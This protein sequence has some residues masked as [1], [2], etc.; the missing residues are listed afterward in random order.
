MASFH[1][2][3]AKRET[4]TGAQSPQVVVRAGKHYVCSACG[5]LIE[6]PADVAEQYILVAPSNPQTDTAKPPITRKQTTPSSAS[7][8]PSST[9]KEQA[10]SESPLQHTPAQPLPASSHRPTHSQETS[11]R[12]STRPTS[13]RTR[14]VSRPI[15]AGK[16]IDGLHVPTGKQLDGAFKWISFQLKVLDRKDSEIKQLKKLLRQQAARPKPRGR[17]QPAGKESDNQAAIK[18][19]RRAAIEHAHADVGKAP[20]Y[21]APAREPPSP[22]QICERGPP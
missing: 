14:L 10:G 19:K 21:A 6:I 15:F 2:P 7:P 12:G 17:P 1:D 16:R 13:R 18:R 4:P 3:P 5:T 8:C 11:S 9:A 22:E 20:A